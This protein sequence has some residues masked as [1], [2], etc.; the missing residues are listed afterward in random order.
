MPGPNFSTAETDAANTDGAAHARAKH[1]PPR[2][3]LAAPPPELVPARM[4]N[5]VL[6]CERLLYLEWA[7]GEF[8]DNWFTVEGR[9]VHKRADKP[10]GEMPPKP[11]TKPARKKR[12][13]EEEEGEQDERLD[14]PPYEARS[15]WLSSE[16]LGITAK[17][18][19]VEGHDSGRV[20]P[21]E[22]KRGKA[23]DLPEGAYLPERAQICAQVLL[24]RAICLP[25]ETNLLRRM[26]AEGCESAELDEQEPPAA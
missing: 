15:V 9:A 23:P 26:E 14:P 24:L 10:G 2:L 5:E 16:R 6:Y 25:D 20:L 19:I 8:D 22:Y 21:I 12:E 11:E 13:V 18:D 7:Q 3:P 1:L 17:I 4:I